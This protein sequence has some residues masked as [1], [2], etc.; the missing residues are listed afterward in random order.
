MVKPQWK[1]KLSPWNLLNSLEF[2]L[3]LLVSNMQNK[4]FGATDFV[5]EI[6]R[7]KNYLDFEKMDAG[8]SAWYSEVYS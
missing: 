7:M 3:E 8:N 4:I 1:T 5:S 2:S 6:T